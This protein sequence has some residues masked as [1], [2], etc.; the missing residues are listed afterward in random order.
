MNKLSSRSWLVFSALGLTVL[1]ACSSAPLEEAR[2][3][4]PSVGMST[5]Y[6]QGEKVLIACD[7]YDAAVRQICQDALFRE[8]LA[9]GAR[10]VVLPP[11][12]AFLND[13]ELDGQLIA[14]AAAQGAKAVFVMALTPVAT[15]PATGF[16]LGLGA[17]SWGGGGGGGIG[18]SAPVGGNR[19]ETALSANGRLTDVGTGRLLWTASF[20]SSSSLNLEAQSAALSRSMLDAAQN[21]GLFQ[22]S[23]P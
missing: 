23:S 16:S 8:M 9:K 20:A 22:R 7:A 11:G 18:L 1:A 3:I 2:W 17:F 6:L 10:P 12:A 21:S 4:D 14:S 13:R 19:T 5:P 15:R